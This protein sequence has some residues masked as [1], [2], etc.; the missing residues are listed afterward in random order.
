MEKNIKN[1]ATKIFRAIVKPAYAPELPIK[2]Q[3]QR[4]DQRN[5]TKEQLDYYAARE[6]RG[7]ANAK[8]PSNFIPKTVSYSGL[9]KLGHTTPYVQPKKNPAPKIATVI[10]APIT[11]TAPTP[12][13]DNDFEK[14]LKTFV[15]P[16]TRAR[17][18]PD[19]L[20]AG[21][22]GGE[23]TYG[24]S[25]AAKT[26]NNYHGIMQWDAAGNRTLRSF[27]SASDS[28]KMYAETINNLVK[29][30]GY[31]IK[32]LNSDQILDVLQEGKTRYEGDNPD[33]KHYVNFIK[34]LDIYKKHNK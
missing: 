21:Q 31:D 9:D 18:I 19:A 14:T 23:S 3:I 30:K 2:T 13:P 15:F 7:M 25:E 5:D 28:S 16:H 27:A 34:S 10:A 6:A 4:A 33:P 8:T 32:K 11:K 26:K 20:A 17:N 29:N 22:T 12:T 1:I 24:R